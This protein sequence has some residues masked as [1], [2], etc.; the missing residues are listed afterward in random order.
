MANIKA[1][2]NDLNSISELSQ[3]LESM[4][5]GYDPE[6]DKVMKKHLIQVNRFF[7]RNG[8]EIPIDVE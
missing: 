3:I 4:R 2:K 1:T 5:G 7:K 6:T 8:L